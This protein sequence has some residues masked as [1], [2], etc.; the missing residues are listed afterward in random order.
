VAFT[1]RVRTASGATAVQVAEY[2]DERQRI[3]KHVGSAH[4]QTELGALLSLA[5]DCWRIRGREC[6]IW[7]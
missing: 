7:R 3:V 4:T 6:W 5:R 1:R 2:A